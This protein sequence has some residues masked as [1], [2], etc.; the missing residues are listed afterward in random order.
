MKPTQ[1]LVLAC[2]WFLL[3]QS[4]TRADDP[5]LIAH[6]KLTSDAEDSSPQ[7]HS[8][9]SH[10]VDVSSEG[11]RFDGRSSHIEVASGNTLQL[12]SRPFSIAMWVNTEEKLDDVLGDLISK[13]DP[14]SRTGFNLSI[15]NSCITLA[16]A[17]Y[18]HLH[19]GID[20]KFC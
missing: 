15:Q 11:G 17:N 7:G 6:W 10:G 4:A 8:S 5:D 13:Y 14:A 12:G 9:S 3:V 2:V 19:F 18:R 20:G 1:I 16:Q